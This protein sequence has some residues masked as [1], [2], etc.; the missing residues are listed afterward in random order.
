VADEFEA[1]CQL[2]TD[3]ELGAGFSLRET[4]RTTSI[5]LVRQFEQALAEVNDRLVRS[6][7]GEPLA[8]L[9]ATLAASDHLAQ[10]ADPDQLRQ[11]VVLLDLELD[12]RA[13]LPDRATGGGRSPRHLAPDDL[14]ECAAA[15]YRVGEREFG[16]RTL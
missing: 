5:W 4:G 7:P 15:A 9:R 16:G 8:G 6:G 2:P 3:P 11:S 14:A 13:N 10:G 12:R 1:A